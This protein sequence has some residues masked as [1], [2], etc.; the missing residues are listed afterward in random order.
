VARSQVTTA[1]DK[2]IKNAV[3]RAELEYL[4]EFMVTPGNID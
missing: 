2:K 3:E 1:A 4:Q